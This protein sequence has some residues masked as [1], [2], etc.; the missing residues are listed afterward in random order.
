MALRPMYPPQKDSPSTF[1]VGDISATDTVLNVS[2]VSVLP[3][4]VPFP[5]TIGIDKTTTETVMVTAI[6]TASNRLTVTRGAP[7][8]AWP[9]TTQVARVLTAQ[10]FKD[11]QDNVADTATE[12]DTARLEI[13]QVTSIVED[14]LG[15]IGDDEY[16]LV[17]DLEDEVA[18]ATSAENAEALRATTAEDNLNSVKVDRTEL[19]QVITDADY[20]V[21]GNQ[22]KA[23]LTRY[24]ATT[25]E[26]T[27]YTKTVPATSKPYVYA[28]ITDATARLLPKSGG[29]MTG[30]LN[31]GGKKITTVAAP[32]EST[33][34]VNKEYADKMLPKSGGAM[35]GHINMNKN[36]ISNCGMV[37]IAPTDDDTGDHGVIMRSYAAEMGEYQYLEFLGP[38]DE[39]VRLGNIYP[40]ALSYDAANKDYVDTRVSKAGDT[41]TG[42]LTARY[43]RA[44]EHVAAP[45]V[46]IIYPMGDDGEAGAKIIGMP[47]EN[48]GSAAV[49]FM[50]VYS[51]ELVRLKNVAEPESEND[52]A[53]KQYVDFF[54]PK[55]VSA[56]LSTTWTGSAAPYTQTVTVTGM[57]SAKNGFIGLAPSATTEQRAAAAAAKLMLTSQGT[58]TVTITADG[59]KPTVT[60][61]IVVTLFG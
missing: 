4:T 26:T 44:D 7:A 5:L 16:G 18:R 21:D 31:M 60:L 6:N 29:T 17:K 38:S 23:T 19:A 53:N 56:T 49:S 9:A 43:F 59:D 40:P 2:S 1:L 58:N 28:A 8:S 12:V 22:V 61:P 36:A 52:V 24:N 32:T 11:L 10:D 27:Q 51:G 15:I 45:G 13:G 50:G 55:Q 30:D 34:V 46:N 35:T 57:T 54:K 14:L 37:I 3:Q 39:P 48:D 20:A 25:K 42:G 47:D 33:D 41:M